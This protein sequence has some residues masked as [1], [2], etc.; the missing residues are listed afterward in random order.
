MPET[1]VSHPDTGRG[2]FLI[3]PISQVRHERMNGTQWKIA[4]ANVNK[5]TFMKKVTTKK[6]RTCSKDNVS[7]IGLT[8]TGEL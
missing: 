6:G 7:E 2:A 5:T 1:A 3:P 8:F 4:L